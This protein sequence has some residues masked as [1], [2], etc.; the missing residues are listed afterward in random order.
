MQFKWFGFN[1]RKNFPVG[2]PWWF[3]T[4]GA[5]FLYISL[6]GWASLT[7]PWFMSHAFIESRGWDAGWRAG[8]EAGHKLNPPG[9]TPERDEER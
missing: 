9:P 1:R 5:N 6:G 4:R 2:G 8:V 7:V 3:I